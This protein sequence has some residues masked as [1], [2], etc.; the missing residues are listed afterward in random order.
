VF[1][2]TNVLSEEK[3]KKNL[4][5]GWRRQAI[6]IPAFCVLGQAQFIRQPCDDAEEDPV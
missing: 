4:Y 2:A 3:S 1:K 5:P 6:E